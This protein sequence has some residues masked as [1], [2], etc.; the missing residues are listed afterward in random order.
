MMFVTLAIA[1]A[2]CTGGQIIEASGSADPSTV[3]G[4]PSNGS[5]DDGTSGGGDGSGDSPGTG[6]GP[7]NGF[8]EPCMTCTAALFPQAPT[9]GQVPVSL[10]RVAGAAGRQMVSFGAP[11]PRGAVTDLAAITIRDA[12]GNEL[13]ARIEELT[14]WRPYGASGGASSIRA[15]LVHVEVDVSAP[16]SYV[17][18]R[19]GQRASRSLG[20][21]PDPKSRWIAVADGE[22]PAAIREP[23]VYATFTPDWL[24]GCMFRTRT[25]QLNDDAALSWFDESMMG[26]AQTA[27]NDVP[28]QVTE[29]I[30]YQNDEAPW[31]FDR[32][33]ALFNVYVRTGEV[34]WLRHAHRAA[35]YY[36]SRLSDRGYFNFKSYDDLKYSYGHSLLVDLMLTGDRSLLPKIEAVGRAANDWTETY[37]IGSQFW[38]ERHHAYALLAALAAWE[39]TGKATYAARADAIMRATYAH[40]ANPPDGMPK[41]GCLPHTR[42]S[43]EG[44]DMDEPVCS[45][46]MTALFA[47][48]VWRYWLHAQDDK[49]LRLLAGFGD[50]IK[51]TALYDGSYEQLDYMVPYYFATSTYQGTEGGPWA[52]VEHTC[53]VAGMVARAAWAKKRLG[54]DAR[55]LQGTLDALMKGC[56]WSL[57]YWHRPD[58]PSSG[59]AEWRL[60]PPRKFNWWFGTTSDL[61]WLLQ[62]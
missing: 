35:Q 39:A 6:G 11:F 54:T 4:N 53:D 16:E 36:A 12:A 5:A 62:R 46:W 18:L 17:F 29:R 52:D 48:A 24:A 28:A 30:D 7:V 27:V 32:A 58:G 47:D 59:K 49:A 21:Q 56:K 60:S 50:W 22:Y 3:G 10:H 14:R 41:D 13:P 42:R 23:A 57:D 31:L 33:L 45:P 15:A 38:T 44:D 61:P 20:N 37:S 25:V 40:A 51:N 1:V 19:W 9:R 2:G 8:D 43:H 34:K 26:F 55:G